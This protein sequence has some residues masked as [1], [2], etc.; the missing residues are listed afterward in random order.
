MTVIG[1]D[2][3][4]TNIKLVELDAGGAVIDRG[5][6]A[7]PRDASVVSVLEAMIGRRT[8]AGAADAP[9]LGVCAPGLAAC[10]ERRIVN[11]PG[12]QPAVE[13]IDWTRR[14]GWARP[15]PVLNDANAAL[16]A[17]AAIGA[18][19]GCAHAVM[20]TLGTGVGGAAMV[21][22]RLLR[23]RS[24]KAGHLGHISLHPDWPRSILGMPGSLEY[25][26]GDCSVHQRSGGRFDS[27]HELVAAHTAGDADATG[28]WLTSVGH[29]A[30][31]I[32]SLVNV[33]DPEVV[34]LAGGVTAAGDA[35]FE[36]L[37]RAVAELEW[38]PTGEP[39]PIVASR[40]GADAGAMGAAIHARQRA[41]SAEG[42]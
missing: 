42:A 17:E 30:R 35:L 24:G 38:R 41:N 15:V 21:D 2:I 39:V 29:L 40:L 4:K 31:G 3:G 10:D 18:A 23:G 19:R 5:E 36:P 33:L 22:G 25:A 11:L 14:L 28:L 1:I 12:G 20:L 34:V 32:A 13:G 8:G 7:T 16:V 6:A 37:R 27:T 9:P 26:I